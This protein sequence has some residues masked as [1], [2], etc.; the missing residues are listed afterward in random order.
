MKRI[1]IKIYVTFEKMSIILINFNL[2]SYYL[3]RYKLI[4][5]FNLLKLGWNFYKLG[6]FKIISITTKILIKR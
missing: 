6:W 4:N 2:I 1:N 5:K 3:K